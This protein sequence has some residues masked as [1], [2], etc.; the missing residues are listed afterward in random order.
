MIL[1][2]NGKGIGEFAGAAV[3]FTTGLGD[4]V[5]T[6]SVALGLDLPLSLVLLLQ[7]AGLSVHWL[8]LVLVLYAELVLQYRIHYL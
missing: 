1:P 8:D 5:C 4:S 3:G 2:I 6:E 7:L